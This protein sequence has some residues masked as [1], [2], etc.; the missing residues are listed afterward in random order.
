M[1]V[2]KFKNNK[3]FPN[4]LKPRKAAAPDDTLN[5]LVEER[6]KPD[7]DFYKGLGIFLPKKF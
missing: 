4:F 6:N 1:V 2:N 7:P 3:E 5:K